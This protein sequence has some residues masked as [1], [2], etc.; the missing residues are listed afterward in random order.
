M[1][2]NFLWAEIPF[3]RIF[4]PFCLGIVSSIASTY[5]HPF[6][7]ILLGVLL[8]SMAIYLL[9]LDTA[10]K[11]VLSKWFGLVM[12]SSLFLAGWIHVHNNFDQNKP[13]YFANSDR[14][15]I[16]IRLSDEPKESGRYWRAEA[17]VIGV[18]DSVSHQAQGKIMVFLEPKNGRVPQ[19]GD[20]I[21]V[22]AG[23]SSLRGERNPGAFN[24]SRYLKFRNIRYQCFAPKDQWVLCDSSRGNPVY[25]A[26]FH[27]KNF[28]MDR[29]EK[30]FHNPQDRAILNA[31]LL[32][33]RS[34]LDNDTKAAFSR[35]G[36][37]HVLAVSGLHVGVIYLL[38][39]FVLG[40]IGFRKNSWK[41][42]IFILTILWFFALIT[43]F[44]PSVSRA[45]VMF[46]TVAIG[47]ALGRYVNIYNTLSF[48][49]FLMLVVNPLNLMNLGFQFS[50][51]AV[52]G[53]VSMQTTIR[54]WVDTTSWFRD[55][56]Y[57]LMAVSLAAQIA[58]FP[59]GLYYFHQLSLSFLIS[60]LVVVP[61]ITV[62]LYGLVLVLLVPGFT[63]ITKC[64][65]YLVSSYL[66]FIRMAVG[67]IEKLPF[68]FLEGI[69][70]SGFE[71]F[72]VM[73]LIVILIMLVWFR[74]KFP[75]V[76][77][78][79]VCGIVLLSYQIMRK[80]QVV[81]SR[82]LIAY[83]LGNH[84]ALFA[85]NGNSLNYITGQFDEEKDWQYGIRP[86]LVM[87][88]VYCPKRPEV[89]TVSDGSQV[90]R[91]TVGDCSIG[92]LNE[93]TRDAILKSNESYDLVLL[94]SVKGFK[95]ERL[96]TVTKGIHLSNK[97]SYS[98]RSYFSN[99]YK[100]NLEAGWDV[101][102][103]QGFSSWPLKSFED[104]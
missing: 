42:T 6:L 74:N 48:S 23:M 84:T 89:E 16:R 93:S 44:A 104:D 27:V 43:G 50:Y 47:Q 87:R 35:T 29:I 68:A 34:G 2:S 18:Y 82:E 73:T 30:R 51:V 14:H 103:T 19:Y 7:A 9:I 90:C 92:V 67:L 95:W 79:I 41:M 96:L 69:P 13:R 55:K 10:R 26:A 38:T 88:G 8:A 58:T 4:L 76:A 25:E 28:M 72:A 101:S 66:W 54:G 49:A 56:V 97:L 102:L 94:Q 59:L 12:Q 63:I 11:Y 17:R 57:N 46:S 65:V 21:D 24:Y 36:T 32:G 22:S 64:L 81:N 39:A 15:A 86:Y 1:R 70:F 75:L 3:V 61:A 78:G 91:F 60:N 53:I 85:R 20:V 80:E 77:S 71:L 98:D 99:W 37:I 62:V 33:E 5:Y 100:K 40:A 83:N 45:S 31:L 52:L